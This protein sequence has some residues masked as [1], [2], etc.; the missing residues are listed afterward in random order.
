MPAVPAEHE[1]GASASIQKQDHLLTTAQRLV[2]DSLQGPTEDR[3]V[4]CAQLGSEIYDP[5]RWQW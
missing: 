4:A 1:R 3:T 2:H 5:H